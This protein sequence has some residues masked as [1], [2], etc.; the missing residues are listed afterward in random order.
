MIASRTS[1]KYRADSDKD[2]RRWGQEARA[3]NKPAEAA[4]P[5]GRWGALLARACC[6]RPA[7]SAARLRRP[8]TAPGQ[9]RTR[10]ADS[11]KGETGA[12]SKTGVSGGLSYFRC[13]V[14]CHDRSH[15]RAAIA[16]SWPE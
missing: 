8:I 13:R 3:P 4:T 9:A 15:V 7:P 2:A 1:A 5:A 11:A 12:V 14:R 16:A 10:H 6:R